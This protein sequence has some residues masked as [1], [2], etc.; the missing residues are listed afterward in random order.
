MI[1]ERSQQ[2]IKDLQELMGGNGTNQF[3]ASMHMFGKE[4]IEDDD[5]VPMSSNKKAGGDGMGRLED[6]EDDEAE[7]ME[8]NRQ[9]IRQFLNQ[10]KIAPAAD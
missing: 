1:L 9:L 10:N 4:P 5:D 3:T 7:I 6:Q 2:R 8:R